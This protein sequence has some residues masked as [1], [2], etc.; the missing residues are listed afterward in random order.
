MR[1]ATRLKT[2]FSA[3]F[4]CTLVVAVPVLWAQSAQTRQ[5]PY[6]PPRITEPPNVG[7]EWVRNGVDAF[8]LQRL[9]KAGLQPAHEATRQ[10]L[11]RRLYFDLIGLPPS[12]EET[13]AFLQDNSEKAYEELVDRLLTDPRYGERWARFWLDLARYADTAGY[14]GDPDLPHVW[15]YRD[16]VI[17]AFNND[18]PYDQFIREQIAGDEVEEIMGAGDLPNA[19]PERVVALTFLR[20][21]PFTEP[22]GDETRHELLSEMTSTVGSVFLGLTVGCAKCHDHKY[23]NISTKDFYRLQSFFSTV[24]LPRPEPGDTFQIGGSLTAAFYRK[25][26]KEWASAQLAKFEQEIAESKQQLQ[27]LKSRLSTTLVQQAGF[28]L[29]AMGGPLGNSYI[30][31]ATPVHQ[32]N[33]HTSIV[34]CDGKAWTFFT[35]NHLELSTGSNA[36]TNPGHWFADLSNPQHVTLGQ[37]TEGTDHIQVA[38]RHHDGEFCQLLIYDHPLNAVE[39]DELASWLECKCV[40]DPPREGLRLWLDAAD[41]DADS[42]SPNP[43]HGSLVSSWTDRIAGIRLAQSERELQPTL[44]EVRS[45]DGAPATGISGV[46]FD[47]KFLLGRINDAALTRDQAGSLVVI[48]TARHSHEGYGFAVGGEGVFL[49]TF[50]NPSAFAQKN[51]DSILADDDDRS[52]SR[53]DRQ[54]YQRLSNREHFLRQNIKRIQP[55][56]MSLRHSYGPPYEPGVPTSRVM[57]RGEYDNPGEVVTPGFLSC[58]TGNDEPAEIRLDP[59]KRWP[60]RSR[61]MAL[62]QWIASA[63]NPLTSRVMVNRLWHWHFGRGIV[64]SPSDFGQLGGGPSHPELLD[65]LAS[66]FIRGKW[67]IRAI[68]KLIVMSAAYRQSSLRSD[69]RC[70]EI[71]P[72]NKLLWRF[73]RRRLEAEAVRDSVLTVSGRLN[74]EQFGLPIFPP[75]PDDIENRVKFSASK[76]D[77]QRGPEGRKRS[78]YIYQQR[79]LTMPFMQ[80]FD[81]LVCDESRPQRQHSVT[82][83]QALAMYNGSFVAEEAQHLAD[84][85]QKEAGQD[86]TKQIERAFLIALS[87]P[88]SIYES[89]ELTRLAEANEFGLA[90]VCRVL[91]NSNEFLYID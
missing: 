50:V 68:Q 75:L 33:L 61:R 91:L 17:D 70:E 39:R 72:D 59:F 60:T 80:S 55:L 74:P 9:E 48:H 83:L 54:E 36:G 66:E 42:T 26:E 88:P 52:V 28:G 2:T 85:I 67:S 12:P 7:T 19:A 47:D 37:Y 1:Q 11:I 18:K 24:A 71:D 38:H 6:F 84:R 53:E 77:T 29:Q 65:W 58:I 34:N 20:L 16:Y 32:G 13:A 73:R 40:G 57:I 81:A 25:G 69:K 23:D 90:S 79:T 78:I 45:A 63:D 41:L 82:P 27:Q 87:R 86:I 64:A 35:D 21:A 43:V 44:V 31:T 14:E 10:Q 8:I 3:A 89:M 76:W 62:A 30:F 49:S 15:R 56:A 22:R 46:R 51:L 5:W 4:I